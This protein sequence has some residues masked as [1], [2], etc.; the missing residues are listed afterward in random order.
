MPSPRKNVRPSVVHR[1]GR[2]RLVRLVALALLW[3]GTTSRAQ[4]QDAA[5]PTASTNPLETALS[6]PLSRETWP[7]WREAYL[8]IFYDENQDKERERIFYEQI[9][10]FFRAATA[11]SAGSLPKEFTNDPMAWVAQAWTYLHLSG[12]GLSDAAQERYLARAEEACRKGMALGDPQA[13]ASYTLAVTL[14]YRRAFQDPNLPLTGEIE[15]GFREAEER[16]SH[17]EQV[18]PQANVNLWRG[19]IAELRGD[20]KSAAELLERAL[21]AHPKDA[22]T[23]AAYLEST[24]FAAKVPGKMGEQSGL[25]ARRFPGDAQIQAL[26]AAA[27]YKDERYAEAADTLDRARRIDEK[28]TRFLGNEGVKA[29]ED[30]RQ[31]TSRTMSGLRAMKARQYEAA[32]AAFRQALAESP[33]NLRAGQL[34]ARALVSRFVPGTVPSPAWV[35]STVIELR[36]LCTQFPRD[37]EI[38]AALAAALVAGGR[39]IEAAEALDRVKELGGNT[40]GL[41]DSATIHTIRQG[42]E[43]DQTTRF[44][45]WA[46]IATVLG[47]ALWIG[48]MFAMGAILAIC[49][50][51]VPRLSFL[52]GEARSRREIW[53]ER[54]YLLVLSLGL[55][56]F[57]ASVPVVAAGLLAVTLALFGMLLAIRIIHYGVL[58]RGLWA[59]WNV[60]RCALIGPGSDVLGVKATSDEHPRLFE[61]LRIVAD[62]LKT[63]PVDT[64]YLTPSSN[65]SVKQEGSGPFGLL[66]KRRRVLEVG[67]STLPLLSREEFHSILAHEYGHFSRNDTF[68]SRFIF[69]V[70]AS[71]ATSLAVMSAAGG[72]LNYINP[73]Y[74]FWWLYL[75]AYTLL[76]NGFS[77]SREFLA[78]RH[79]V[80][81]YGKEAFVSGLTK[82]AVDGVLFESSVYANIRHLL[83]QGKAFTNAFDAFRHFREET[84]MVESR[85]KLLDDLRQTRPRWFDTHPTYAE[86][87]AAIAEF[88]DCPPAGESEPAIELLADHQ[89]VEA[90]L[91]AILTQYVHANL[92]AIRGVGSDVD[93]AE[94]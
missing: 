47:A 13:V 72:Y 93:G 1:T 65:I 63:R 6:R 82:V 19:K 84:A 20:K 37:P 64:V 14:V 22:P 81:A 33:G 5:V 59:F 7:L 43:S 77:R 52:T 45:E 83:S 27:L 50:P 75:R 30:G 71:L 56:V 78:D 48:I 66:G 54:F 11:A 79:A 62:R 21:R 80:A 41:F 49:I 18:S 68:Y 29:I 73:F 53:L 51:R 58:H 40:G 25:F 67:I 12:D 55:L 4:A 61:S 57:Y 42:A 38:Q 15:R 34:L 86:R 36:S 76:A 16:L 3:A 24:L 35:E 8:R 28:V 46:A 74:W 94:E 23:A 44:W 10:S 69:Q 39:N 87:L 17:V 91:T 85:Q 26:H 88:P 60:L 32:C 92:A 90:K 2:R 9:R 89:G 31:L 70:S